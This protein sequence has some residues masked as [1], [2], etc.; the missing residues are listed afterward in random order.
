[1]L[2]L[3]LQVMKAW[4]ESIVATLQKELTG[5]PEIQLVSAVC[6]A[7]CLYN[8]I[9]SAHLKIDKFVVPLMRML[10][11]KPDLENELCPTYRYLCGLLPNNSRFVYFYLYCMRMCC[12]FSLFS[13]YVEYKLQLPFFS[14]WHR[15]RMPKNSEQTGCLPFH[16]TTF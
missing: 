16:Y 13:I 11:I 2:F 9:P 14:C 12:H 8:C 4:L 6:V 7:C 15:P 3:H 5:N 1:M 10:Y